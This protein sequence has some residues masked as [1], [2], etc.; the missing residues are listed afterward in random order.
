MSLPKLESS[1]NVTSKVISYRIKARKSKSTEQ[2]DWKLFFRLDGTCNS[3]VELSNSTGWDF[4]STIK[5]NASTG[6]EYCEWFVCGVCGTKV[7]FDIKQVG[8]TVSSPFT[9]T[10]RLLPRLGSPAITPIRLAKR[11]SPEQLVSL[12]LLQSSWS[13]LHK[14][15]FRELQKLCKTFKYQTTF[16]SVTK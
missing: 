5:F 9:D 14:R 3:M 7:A 13:N 15:Y 10:N 8:F 4:D 16:Y 2:Y 6:E 11:N 1:L 12:P